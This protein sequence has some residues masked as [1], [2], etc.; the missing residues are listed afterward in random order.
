M[1]YCSNNFIP[2][3]ATPCKCQFLGNSG[4]GQFFQNLGKKILIDADAVMRLLEIDWDDFEHILAS[5]FYGEYGSGFPETIVVDGQDYWLKQ[6]VQ[7]WRSSEAR[8]RYEV[9]LANS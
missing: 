7:A 4:K 1:C 3:K 6:E 8:H 2:Q 9:E 5:R